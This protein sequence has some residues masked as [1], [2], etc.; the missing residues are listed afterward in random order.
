VAR[1]LP[2]VAETLRA[3]R[4][5]DARARRILLMTFVPGAVGGTPGSGVTSPFPVPDRG[6]ILLLCNGVPSSRRANA[7]QEPRW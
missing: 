6:L 5:T 4:A 7:V 2:S 1:D 3:G